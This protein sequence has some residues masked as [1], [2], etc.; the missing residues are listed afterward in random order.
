MNHLKLK[1]SQTCKHDP[2]WLSKPVDNRCSACSTVQ[3]CRTQCKKCQA[4]FCLLCVKWNKNWQKCPLGHDVHLC[5]SYDMQVCGGKRGC[6]RCMLAV[7][8]LSL[9]FQDKICN[10][11]LHAGCGPFKMKRSDGNVICYCKKKMVARDGSASN[12]CNLY[13]NP[14]KGGMKC[15]SCHA[16]VCNKCL[17]NKEYV[18]QS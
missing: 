11:T 16:K 4:R 8:N 15:S 2:Q 7:E 13:Q 14:S 3:S 10:I 6:Q 9:N 18:V 5:G 12:T 1:S 17:Q